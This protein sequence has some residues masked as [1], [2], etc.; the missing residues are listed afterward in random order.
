MSAF[1]GKIHYWLYSKIEV[2]ERI[3]QE[4]ITLINENGVTTTEIEDELSLLHSSPI[5]GRLEDIVDHSNIHGYLQERIHSVEGRIADIVKFYNDKGLSIM[6]LKNLYFNLGS[7]YMKESSIQDND[8]NSLYNHLYD[9]LLEGMPC[10]RVLNIE[11][12][13]GEK[14]LWKTTK[15]LHERYWGENIGLYYALMD[16]FIEGFTKEYDGSI[17]YSRNGNVRLFER[18]AS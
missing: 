12:S 3:Y 16:S 14:H 9:H 7:W 10:D 17:N 8:L 13:N 2:H 1:L 5:R 18:M 11:I 4:L 6:E 15:C